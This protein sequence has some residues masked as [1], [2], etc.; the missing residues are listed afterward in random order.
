MRILFYYRGS[1]YLGMSYLMSVAKAAGHEIDLGP[2]VD[3]RGG[4]GW[5]STGP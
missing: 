1:E 5:R 2:L 4:R 3:Q